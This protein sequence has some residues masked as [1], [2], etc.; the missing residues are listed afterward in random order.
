MLCSASPRLVFAWLIFFGD[1]TPEERKR[2]AAI[3]VLFIASS[4]FWAS[5]EQA[6]SSLS[7]FAERNTDRHVPGFIAAILRQGE[8]PA[9]WYQFVQPIFV[10]ALAP[11][12]AW[13]WLRMGKREPSSPAK[14]SIGLFLRRRRVRG[15]G[16]RRHD[17]FRRRHG[18]SDVAEC[19]V[20]SCKRSG[21]FASVRSG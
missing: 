17:C 3:L 2:S 18:G 21:S 11:V 19:R 13:L 20:I 7:L 12:F 5:F 15:D 1:W 14:F 16:S 8:F 10:V 6:G 9:S 4:L